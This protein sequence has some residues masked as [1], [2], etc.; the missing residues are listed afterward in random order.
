MII[1]IMTVTL[2]LMI[3]LPLGMIGFPTEA[4]LIPVGMSTI[5]GVGT[6]GMVIVKG[7]NPSVVMIGITIPGI[8]PDEMNGVVALV[9][10]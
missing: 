8:I 7:I 1:E 4:G 10:V 6:G 2:P 3:I 5:A 9:T